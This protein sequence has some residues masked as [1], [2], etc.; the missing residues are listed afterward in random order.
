MLAF[1]EEWLFSISFLIILVKWES[2]MFAESLIILG[3]ILSGLV[4][5]FGFMY[6]VIL[7]I[8]SA[9][10]CGKSKVLTFRFVWFLIL[11][12]FR[13]FLYSS[14]MLLTVLESSNGLL[15]FPVGRMPNEF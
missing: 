13:R 4:S 5:F 10:V 2:V 7:F 14:I 6:L 3:K 12:M 8:F 9:A 11:I 15:R 1:S